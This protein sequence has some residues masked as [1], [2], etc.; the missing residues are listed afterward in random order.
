MINISQMWNTLKR[1][2]IIVHLWRANVSSLASWYSPVL[3]PWK[4]SQV[5]APMPWMWHSSAQASVPCCWLPCW[6]PWR[7]CWDSCHYRCTCCC[8]SAGWTAGT[9]AAA[10][11]YWGRNEAV[12]VRKTKITTRVFLTVERKKRK[13]KQQR[14]TKGWA[15]FSLSS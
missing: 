6:W 5:R 12:S 1:H 11:T 13:E 4:A 8:C 9:P 10:R 7:R 3:G 14:M 15:R 2:R